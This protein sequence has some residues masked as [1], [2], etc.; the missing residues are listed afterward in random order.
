MESTRESKRYKNEAEAT[1]AHW[2]S[3]MLTNILVNQ[4]NILNMCKI[5]KLR[6]WSE[7]VRNTICTYFLFFLYISV[8]ICKILA[9][10]QPIHCPSLA[11]WDT[12]PSKPLRLY[13]CTRMSSSLPISPAQLLPKL[14]GIH[15]KIFCTCCHKFLSSMVLIRKLADC[16]C[17]ISMASMF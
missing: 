2:S 15:S 11:C 5:S 9:S 6:W 13:S 12:R 8:S 16:C 14:Q 10:F 17:N 1:R 7:F 3:L 4:R